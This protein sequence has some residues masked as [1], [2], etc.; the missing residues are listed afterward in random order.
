LPHIFYQ[1]VGAAVYWLTRVFG[2]R[3][4]FRYGDPSAP[5]GAQIHLG[6]AWVML[7]TTRSGRASPAQIGAQ[8]QFVTVFVDDVDAHHQR[9]KAAGAR[10]IEDL[11]ETMYGE[12]QYAAEDLEGHHWM[13]A[14]HVKDVAPEEWGA[15][16][17]RS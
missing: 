10:I 17:S 1:D 7:G 11:N 13:F 9:T 2:F 3:E 14:T 8:T 16:V 4:H 15:T 12:R 6:D 5:Q